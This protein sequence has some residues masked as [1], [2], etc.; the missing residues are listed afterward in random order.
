M[1]EARP[2][3][4]LSYARDDRSLADR[5]GERLGEAGFDLLWD[6]NLLAGE[7]L[8]KGIERFIA[9]SHVFLP[10]ITEGSR[11]RPWVHQE[12]GYALALNV[13][14]LPVS[15]GA[16][17]DGLLAQ[18]HAAQCSD[19]PTE[20]ELEA[21][22]ERLSSLIEEA[23]LEHPAL[24]V[25]ARDRYD[26]ARMLGEYARDVAKLR[27]RGVVRQRG[28]G[29]SFT[30]PDVS[31]NDPLWSRRLPA[32]QSMSAR[33]R[34]MLRAEQ[35]ALARHAR[36]AGCRLIVDL[37]ALAH[38]YPG[39]QLLARLEPLES[40]LRSLEDVPVVIGHRRG[41]AEPDDDDLRSTTAVGDWYLAEAVRLSR[42]MGWVQTMLTRHTPTIQR[43]IER[44][45]DDLESLLGDQPGGADGALDYTLE[46]IRALVDGA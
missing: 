17:P 16:P 35:Q 27:R 41:E 15:V 3:I 45:D 9:H 46:Q 19:P 38:K 34:E 37:E 13:P 28:L 12:I 40:F 18:I 1:I 33:E 5:L 42:D 22:I 2:R 10:L 11:V 4:F 14:V 20:E 25:V 7:V 8:T 31:E 24:Y 23:R 26:R 30:I 36:A 43:E 32:G 21:V 6:G 29:G 44:F 39:E